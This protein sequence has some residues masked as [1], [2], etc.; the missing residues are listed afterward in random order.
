MAALSYKCKSCGGEMS[1]DSSGE[2]ICEYCGSRFSLKDEDIKD[3]K[4]FRKQLLEYLRR[5]HDEKVS[6]GSEEDNRYSRLWDM[7]QTETFMSADGEEITLNYLYSSVE[8]VGKIRMFLTRNNIIYVFEGKDSYFADRAVEM[9][10]RVKYPAADV[11]GLRDCFPVFAGRYE[12]KGGVSDKS[13][14]LV[15]ERPANLFPLSMFGAF[16]PEHAA[17]IVSRME[18]I[19]CVL[20]YSGLIHGG[21]TADS[22]FINPFSHHGAL[23]GGWYLAENK[24][25]M[26]RDNRDLSDVR[27]TADHILGIHRNEVPAEF[28]RFLKSRPQ[29]SAYDDFASWDEVIEK[30][31]GGR[32]FAGHMDSV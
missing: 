10:S 18:N 22:F 28:D 2:L 14:M 17:W 7:A 13:V 3:Y 32:R 16:T 1:V 4:V 6:G 31:F 29:K 19:C 27:K 15:Y 11:R 21:I 25:D 23:I 8:Q 24:C 12:L 20:E 9:V 26:R 30:G 5:R